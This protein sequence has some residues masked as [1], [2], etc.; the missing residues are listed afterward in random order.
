VVFETLTGGRIAFVWPH[1]FS[2][3]LLNGR[4]EIVAPDGSVLAR[5]GDEIPPGT[6]AGASSGTLSEPGFDICGVNGVYYP[7]A[8]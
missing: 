7:P 6:L 8:S 2:A 5:E 3:W 1:G 4:A